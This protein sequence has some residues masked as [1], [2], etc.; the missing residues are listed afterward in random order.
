MLREVPTS[1]SISMLDIIEIRKMTESKQAEMATQKERITKQK[2]ADAKEYG[3]TQA[4]ALIPKGEEL[5]RKATQAG[6]NY[7]DVFKYSRDCDPD[8]DVALSRN[9]AS[10]AIA[11]ALKNYFSEKGFKIEEVE[12]WYDLSLCGVYYRTV[13]RIFW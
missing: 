10:D 11:M 7:A 3:E 8:D 6:I 4:I 2:I 5:V 1:G 13:V 12:E 9:R